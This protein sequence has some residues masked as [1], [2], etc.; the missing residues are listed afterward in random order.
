MT[1]QDEFAPA[2]T[3]AYRLGLATG[4]IIALAGTA[5]EVFRFLGTHHSPA[6][7]KRDGRGKFG[8][9]ARV[10]RRNHDNL[11]PNPKR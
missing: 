9:V 4:S 10:R 6:K 5:M 1:N 8:S 11:L 7:G 2:K 3:L